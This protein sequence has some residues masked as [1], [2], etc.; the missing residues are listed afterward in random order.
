MGQFLCGS[1]QNDFDSGASCLDDIKTR[2]QSELEACRLAF[3]GN[4]ATK[5]VKNNNVGR[6]R[7]FHLEVSVGSK[8][9]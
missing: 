4:A 8:Y 7:A 2:L 3:L 5:Q 1:I 6:C 9:F